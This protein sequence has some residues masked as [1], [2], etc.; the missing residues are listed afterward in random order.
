MYLV[1]SGVIKKKSNTCSVA[2]EHLPAG[3]LGNVRIH[4]APELIP[5]TYNNNSVVASV[6]MAALMQPFISSDSAEQQ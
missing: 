4:S 6:V 2:A 5:Y 3:R 1:F